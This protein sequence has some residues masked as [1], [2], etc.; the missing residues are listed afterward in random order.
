MR[1]RRRATHCHTFLVGVSSQVT[2]KLRVHELAKELGVSSKELLTALKEQGEFVKSASSIIEAPVA[3][4]LRE[5]FTIR[6]TSPPQSCQMSTPRRE[7]PPPIPLPPRPVPGPRPFPP[8]P[9]PK[10]CTRA[11]ATLPSTQLVT[12]SEAYAIVGVRP[13]AIR[14]WASRGYLQSIGKR[15]RAALYDRDDLL[16]V[17]N[18]TRSRTIDPAVS[19]ELY[20]PHSH[21]NRL[22]TTDEVAR[23]FSVAPSTVRSWVRRGH[24]T[25]IRRGARGW[26]FK[27][28]LVLIA[29]DDRRRKFTYSR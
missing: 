16:R 13:E 5:T 6:P 15:G 23:L 11:P 8:R 3:R 21:Y 2:S 24:L 22:I 12:V 14:K 7:V 1:V 4:R 29:A 25:P 10:P 28:G 26:L 27:I 18:E 19:S 17:R 9:A 20:V